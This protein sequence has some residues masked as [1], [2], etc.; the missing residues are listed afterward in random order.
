MTDFQISPAAVAF[1]DLS[2]E[3]LRR[4]VLSTGSQESQEIALEMMAGALASLLVEF[5]PAKAGAIWI[6]AAADARLGKA[7][8]P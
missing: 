2:V 6:Q 7:A 8:R 5:C 1:Y 3:S 4:V